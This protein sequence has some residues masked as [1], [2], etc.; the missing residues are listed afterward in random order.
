MSKKKPDPIQNPNVKGKLDF[1]LLGRVFDLIKGDRKIF[2]WA[3]VLTLTVAVVTPL[4]PKTIQTIIDEGVLEYDKPAIVQYTVVL[5]ALL[6]G[7]AVFNYL[8]TFT[9]NL[10]G[11]NAVKELRI[12]VY[13]HVNRYRMQVFDKTPIGTLITRTVSDVEKVADIFAQG[14]INIIGDF[15]QMLFIIGIMF[16]T[17]WQ[18]TLMVLIP[19]PLL[20]ASGWIFKE[21]VKVSFRE[22]RNQISRINAFL[23]EHITGMQIIQLFNRQK[24]ELKRFRAISHDERSANLKAVLYYSVFFP[25][26]EILQAISIALL[27]WYGTSLAAKN[28]FTFGELT[29]F[30]LLIQQLFRPIRQIADK[31]NTLQ[32]GLVASERIYNLL[33]DKRFSN[34]EGTIDSGTIKGNITLDKVWFAYNEPEWILKGISFEAKQ[35]QMIAIVGHTG[36]GKTTIVNLINRLYEIQ[37]GQILVDGRDVQEYQLDFLRKE[38]AVVLQDVFLFSGTIAE[39]ISLFDPNITRDKIEEAAKL[40]GAHKFIMALPNG[41]DYEVQE[42]GLTLSAGQRQLISFIRAIVTNPSVLILDEA[43]SSVDNETEELIQHATEVMLKGRTSIVIAHRLSTIKRADQIMVMEKGEIKERGTHN[44]L[45]QHEGLY[46]KLYEL[47]FA[48][49]VAELDE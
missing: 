31:F 26:I 8:Q 40:V 3:I 41:Y 5:L 10:L 6:L 27:V 32:M 46:K 18:V 13:N 14:L 47:Q 30:I 15:L 11:Q 17:N 37:K 49:M 35:G 12:K 1:S 29:G 21:A 39:N 44:A 24:E 19:F 33:D 16:Y 23:Q 38:V 42:R 36:A 48:G 22:V 25:A 7:Q 20:L 4:I 34:D 43:T 2:G 9:T 28:Q 45:L